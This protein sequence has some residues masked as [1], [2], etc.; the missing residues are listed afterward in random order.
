[1][2]VTHTMDEGEERRSERAVLGDF[3]GEGAVGI[4]T[5]ILTIIGLSGFGPEV[6]ISIATIVIGM[7]FLLEA[8]AVSMRFPAFLAEKRKELPGGTMSVGVAAEFIGGLMGILLGV[9]SL[10][11]LSR[12]V[13]ASVAVI[14]YGFT[15][16]LSSGTVLRFNL[17]SSGETAEREQHRNIAL[18]AVS[19]AANFEFLFGVSVIILGILA[20]SGGMLATTLNLAALLILG[21]SG[22]LTAAAVTVRM[23][24]LFRG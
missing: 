21:V 23:G 12:L 22:F 1:M 2:N 20:L 24:R 4:T 6:M 7:A 10:T 9:L 3:L 18:E 5:V 17:P 14:L 8:G 15:L 19:T 16:A 13:L 11:G